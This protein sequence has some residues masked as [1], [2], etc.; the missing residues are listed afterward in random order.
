MRHSPAEGVTVVE[1]FL[2]SGAVFLGCGVLEYA[3]CGLK[4]GW[5][6]LAVLPAWGLFLWMIAAGQAAKS[7]VM[8]CGMGD[9]LTLL[10]LILPAGA[11]LAL[12]GLARLIRTLWRGDGER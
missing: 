9:A 10:F 7:D 5:K 6:S 2:F 3:L 12:G 11:G 1:L 8:F 4:R